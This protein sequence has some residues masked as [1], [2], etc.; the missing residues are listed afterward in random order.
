MAEHIDSILNANSTAQPSAMGDNISAWDL[1]IIN[2]WGG[3]VTYAASIF[4]WNFCNLLTC[5]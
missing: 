1:F 2:E 3:I 5:I 4:F